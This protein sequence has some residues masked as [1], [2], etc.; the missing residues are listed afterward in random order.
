MKSRFAPNLIGI[1]FLVLGIVIPGRADSS[2]P[3]PA[4]PVKQEEKIPGADLPASGALSQE[5]QE[6]LANRLFRELGSIDKWELHP[7]IT[8]YRTII[9]RCPE[10]RSATEACWRLANLYLSAMEPPNYAEA[11]WVLEHMRT[12][13]PQSPLNSFALGR[14]TFCY[15]QTGAFQKAADLYLEI[16]QNM[17]DA[18]PQRRIPYEFALAG[19]YQKL[20]QNDLAFPLLQA[21]IEKDPGRQ[22]PECRWALEILESQR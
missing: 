3:T 13:Y 12:R 15:Q 7:F 10:A 11:I 17:G 8:N 5:D 9:E 14:L 18:E 22:T 20:A 2:T 21:I 6:K 1:L 4:S 16:L 19:I